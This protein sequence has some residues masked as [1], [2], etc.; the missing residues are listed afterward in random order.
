MKTQ[1][2]A[3]IAKGSCQPSKARMT[4]GLKAVPKLKRDKGKNQG[5]NASFGSHCQGELSAER[6]ED[7]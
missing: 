1:A 6:R 7:D 2:L 4:D 3:P 5:V